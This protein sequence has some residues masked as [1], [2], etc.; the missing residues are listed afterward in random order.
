MSRVMT[1]EFIVS[2]P[3]LFKPSAIPGT[4]QEPK[5]S[6]CMLFPKNTDMSKIK[7][8]INSVLK[9]KYKTKEEIPS[10]LRNPIR[11]GDVDKP[12]DASY[13]GMY[14]IN[15]KSKAK[16]GI[17]NQQLE[18]ILDENELYPGCKARAY[19]TAYHYNQAGNIGVGISL[20]TMQKTGEGERLGGTSFDAM[21]DFQP[22]VSEVDSS[23]TELANDDSTWLK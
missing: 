8:L 21:S 14:F 6:V 13:K 18:E 23:T 3:H 2:Y 7:D 17:V 20:Q 1:P 9:D 15:A 5:Y 22:I 11:D 4:N 12:N 10:N 16:P 19:I